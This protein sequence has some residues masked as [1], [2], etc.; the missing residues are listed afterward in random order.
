[1][2][3]EDEEVAELLFG[4]CLLEETEGRGVGEEGWGVL[5]VG[6]ENG[7]TTVFA[8][9]KSEESFECSNTNDLRLIPIIQ[10]PQNIA[11][12][13]PLRIP[14]LS[15]QHQQLIIPDI[16]PLHPRHL[17]IFLKQTKTLYKLFIIIIG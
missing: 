2:L 8:V 10:M 15:Q 4:H 11:N 1:M 16:I 14:H 13:L 9:I 17:R 6:F 12:L 5:G 7:V 3:L